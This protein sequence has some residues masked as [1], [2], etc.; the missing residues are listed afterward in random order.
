MNKRAKLPLPYSTLKPLTS[1][2]SP[3][4]KSKGARLHSP[5]TQITQQTNNG[6]PMKIQKKLSPR[7]KLLKFNLPKRTKKTKTKKDKQTS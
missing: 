6:A 3:S 2:L 4:E 5:N 7:N 1:S